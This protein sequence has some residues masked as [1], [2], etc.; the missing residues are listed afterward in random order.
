M[1]HNFWYFRRLQEVQIWCK[2]WGEYVLVEKIISFNVSILSSTPNVS[3]LIF[4]CIQ[5]FSNIPLEHTPDPQPT[6][7]EG[8]PFIWG[9]RDSWGML[10]GYVGVFLECRIDEGYKLSSSFTA[11]LSFSTD[12]WGL[13]KPPIISSH[14][15]IILFSLIFLIS[16]KRIHM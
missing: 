8:I 10:Q 4:L 2:K 15:K 5:E 7:Y 1:F 3:W 16:I 11:K 9:F 14:L 13:K 12:G 6:V